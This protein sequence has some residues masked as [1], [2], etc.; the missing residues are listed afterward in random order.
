MLCTEY[1]LIPSPLC[2]GPT[3]H[4][5]GMSKMV[6]FPHQV[7]ECLTKYLPENV[8]LEH[9][10]F[11]YPFITFLVSTVPLGNS[12]KYPYL[13]HGRLFGFPKGRRGSRLWNSEGMG[14][15]LRLE[16]RRHGR[17]HRWDFLRRKCTVSYLK[18]LSLWTFIVRK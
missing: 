17:F 8:L 2:K 4:T 13:Y 16:I 6:C 18:T 5:L 12:R 15:Y 9:L 7:A 10:P 14:R 3:N 11:L 1:L